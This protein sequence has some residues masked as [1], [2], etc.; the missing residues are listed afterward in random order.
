MTRHHIDNDDLTVGMQILI[1]EAHAISD[2]GYV[3]NAGREDDWRRWIAKVDL[4]ALELVTERSGLRVHFEREDVPGL[5]GREPKS[6]AP[7]AIGLRREITDLPN[8]LQKEEVQRVRLSVYRYDEHGRTVGA[9]LN[10]DSSGD[11]RLILV[12][13]VGVRT[14]RKVLAY[15]RDFS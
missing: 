14:I 15:E 10:R 11:E 13:D 9:A 4:N 8:A 5:V 6:R 1:R 3:L 7:G 12:T 2:L